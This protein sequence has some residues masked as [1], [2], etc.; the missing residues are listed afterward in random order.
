MKLDSLVRA[1]EAADPSAFRDI[2]LLSL[3]KRGFQPSLA[4]G[5]N[6]GGADFLVS[7]L[8]PNPARFAVAISVEK[9]WQK[10]LMSDAVKAR[11]KLGVDN[12]LFLSSRVIT[13]PVFQKISDDLLARFQIQVRKSD[14]KDLASQAE[15][16]GFTNDILRALGIDVPAPTAPPFRRPDL[17]QDAAYAC[18]FF[19]TDAQAFRKTVVENTVLAAVFSAGGRADREPVVTTT[20]LGL[21]LA[22]NQL[23]QVSSA[24]DR[25][26]QEGRLTSKNGSVALDPRSLDL[27]TT[28]SALQEKELESLRAQLDALLTPHVKA[29]AKPRA[30]EALLEDLGA[31]WLQMGRSTSSALGAD[32]VPM[33]AQAPLRDRLRR[34]DAKLDVLG[35]VDPARRAKLL[36]ECCALAADSPFGRALTAGEVFMNLVNMKTPHVFRAFGGGTELCVLL[37]TSVAMPLLCS[38]LYD[39]A[40]QDF[41][42]AAKHGYDQIM[43]HGASVVL[44]RDYLE[45]VASHL[46]AARDYGAVIDDGDLRG[47]TNAF[48]AHYVALRAAA[49]ATRP[50]E[51]YPEYLES[52]GARPSSARADPDTE[53]SALMP[54][55]ERLFKSYNIEVESLSAK[56]PSMKKAQMALTYAM[57]ERHDLGRPEVLVRHDTTTLGWLLDHQADAAVAYVLCTWD[58]LHPYVQS[59]EGAAWDVLDPVALG[60]VLSMASPASEEVKL[61]SPLFAALAMSTDA[62]RQAAVV[63]DKLVE[64]ERDKLNDAMLRKTAAAF[65]KDWLG[66]TAKD[67][68]P[69]ALQQDWE[70]W[71]K[72]HLPAPGA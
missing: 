37:D 55:L 43:A 2:A 15:L 11:Q 9:G 39:T 40:E 30:V 67:R 4:D 21:G 34:L 47:S 41:F 51:A 46:L 31:L 62:E 25:M 16:G 69:I 32:D 52:F 57:H 59:H 65:K 28:L 50:L 60:D 1:I 61:V 13:E 3:A 64:L 26:L 53:R 68:R 22:S 6:D 58:K 29:A 49:V 66:R 36:Q 23:A 24:I 12:L 20:A 7:V 70:A 71:K 35:V 48:V 72:A 33:L 42:V 63:W 17:R 38:L 45:E 18:A 14:A 8:P 56:G 44:P 10:K 19:G 5:P 27:W 54:K